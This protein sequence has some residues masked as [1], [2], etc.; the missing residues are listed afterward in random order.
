MPTT[1]LLR[2]HLVHEPSPRL[3]LSLWGGMAVVD[4]ARG[5]QA[6]TPVQV[7]LLALLAAAC[8]IG[9][10]LPAALA[11]GAISWLVTVGFV[12]NTAGELSITGARDV[13]LLGVIATAALAGT[14]V[15]R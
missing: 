6:P 7:G 14:A 3:F 2:A 15:G 12:L 9:Q 11:V 13:L 8:S 1:S 10:R 4:V 5:W